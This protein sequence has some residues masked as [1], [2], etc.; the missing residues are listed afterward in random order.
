MNVYND[1][2]KR[3]KL[4]RQTGTNQI[5]MDTRSTVD[6]VI[7]FWEPE[8]LDMKENE[9][10]HKYVARYCVNNGLNLNLQMHLYA[11]LA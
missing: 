2:P 8:L 3:S 5:D 4:L 9:K 6:E 10:N 1:Q 7:E 11:G